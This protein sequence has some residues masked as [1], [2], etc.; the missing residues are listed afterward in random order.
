MSSARRRTRERAILEIIEAQPIRT[1]AELATALARRGSE[2]TQ[3]TLS[4][5]IQRLGIVK[6]PGMNGPRYLRPA[7]ETAPPNPRRVLEVA[8]SEF[9]LE[10]GSGDAL[11]AIRTLSGCANAVAVAIDESGLDGVVATV[12]GDDSILVLCRDVDIRSRLTAELR[13]LAGL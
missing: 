5:D 12:A 4:R 9:A 13:S 7:P 8:L 2:A 1:Q 6:L 10:V 3:A 11:L